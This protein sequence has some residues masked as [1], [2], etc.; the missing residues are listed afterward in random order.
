MDFDQLP[1]LALR[2]SAAKQAPQFL[3]D[4]TLELMQP[5]HSTLSNSPRSLA[6]DMTSAARGAAAVP[7][8]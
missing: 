5:V 2:S 8:Y 1:L 6:A 3:V 4:Q 7:P